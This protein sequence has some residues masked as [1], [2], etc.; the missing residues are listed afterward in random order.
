VWAGQEPLGVFGIDQFR[1]GQ[2]PA[3]KIALPLLEIARVL[4]RLDHFASGIINPITAQ[5]VGAGALLASLIFVGSQI[6]QN[7]PI[8]L[9]SKSA[10]PARKIN[11]PNDNKGQICTYQ[12][13][14]SD[15]RS[16]CSLRTS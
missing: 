14:E 7:T 1:L 12:Q 15:I 5:I 10:E 16:R 13:R 8:L 4:A 11:S 3:N 6:R 9:Y 2:T